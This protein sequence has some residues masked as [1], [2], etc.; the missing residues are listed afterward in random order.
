MPELWVNANNRCDAASAT[1]KSINCQRIA[2][3]PALRLTYFVD[4]FWDKRVDLGAR[5][6]LGETLKWNYPL[7]LDLLFKSQNIIDAGPFVCKCIHN[8]QVFIK[9]LDNCVRTSLSH[10]S[11]FSRYLPHPPYA[12][13]SSSKRRD[14]CVYTCQWCHIYIRV[15][16]PQQDVVVASIRHSST[17]NWARRIKCPSNFSLSHL[18]MRAQPH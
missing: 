2:R 11:R 13:C 15:A 4:S 1:D 16:Q 12:F 6:S 8:G 7:G 17:T 18:R 5:T 9:Y 3:G 10:I 14:N